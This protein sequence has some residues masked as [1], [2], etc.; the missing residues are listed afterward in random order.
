MPDE[1]DDSAMA[2]A[3]AADEG[4]FEANS[5]EEA[6]TDGTSRYDRGD[7][8]RAVRALN[9]FLD[10]SESGDNR[11]PE[12]TYLAAASHIR[13]GN[14]ATAEALLESL[15][16]AWPDHALADEA[17]TL[18]EDIRRR[19]GD[20]PVRNRSSRPAVDTLESTGVE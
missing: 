8:R 14:D 4:G 19:S 10:T 1:V 7:Y 2:R 13:L 20:E 18:L 11:R 5:V 15:L 16:R 6:Y 12:A 3:D 9:R 17:R